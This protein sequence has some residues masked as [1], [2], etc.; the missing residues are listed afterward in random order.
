[1]PDRPKCPGCNQ[2]KN[3]LWHGLGVILCQACWNKFKIKHTTTSG[4]N[5]SIPYTQ[6]FQHKVIDNAPASS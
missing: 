4:P 3:S 2:E 5:V 1:M 6:P